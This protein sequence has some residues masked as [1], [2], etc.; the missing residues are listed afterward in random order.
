MIVRLILMICEDQNV[1]RDD[2]DCV[3]VR[4]LGPPPTPSITAGATVGGPRCMDQVS[5]EHFR[6]WEF[7]RN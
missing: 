5:N 3:M 1:R 7:S 6:C 2:L 4:S